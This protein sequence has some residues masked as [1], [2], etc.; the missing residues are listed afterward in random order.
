MDYRIVST[1]ALRLVGRSTRLA[2]VHEGDNLQ[3]REFVASVPVADTVALKALNDVEPRGVLAV[4]TDFDDGRA[5]GSDF[6]Y[7]YGVATIGPTP[8]GADVIDVGAATWAVFRPEDSSDAAL[9]A[10]WPRI[11]T[12]WLP[13]NG[14]RLGP[15]PEIVSMQVDDDGSLT[16]ELWI[17]VAADA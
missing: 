10:L 2:L 8:T 11:F 1:P 5:E 16:R 13:A 3:L 12:E 9:Q 15:G 6:T 7:L 17:C 4:C 14:W